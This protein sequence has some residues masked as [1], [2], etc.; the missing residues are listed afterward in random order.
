MYLCEH[1]HGCVDT[2]LTGFQPV[3]RGELVGPSVNFHE[4][5][6]FVCRSGRGREYVADVCRLFSVSKEESRDDV[7][8]LGSRSVLSETYQQIK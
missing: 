7:G 5:H 2:D 4:V 6:E 3:K 8:M 1:A